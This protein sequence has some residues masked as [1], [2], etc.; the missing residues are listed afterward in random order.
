MRKS[1]GEIGYAGADVASA[2][3]T[4]GSAMP[5]AVQA[6]MEQ[7]LGA[8][9]SSVRVHEGPEAQAVGALAYAQGTNIH[10]APGQYD[11]GSQRGQELLGHELTHVMQ[12]AQGRVST[13]QSK[14]AP[15][16]QDP[17]LEHEADVRGAAAARGESIGGHAANGGAATRRRTSQAARASSGTSSP[18]QRFLSVGGRKLTQYSAKIGVVAYDTALEEGNMGA[19]RQFEEELILSVCDRVPYLREF[20]EHETH[21]VMVPRGLHRNEAKNVDYVPEQRLHQT[22][23]V[24]GLAGITGPNWHLTYEVNDG[25]IAL[26]DWEQTNRESITEEVIK[27]LLGLEDTRSSESED[28]NGMDVV[29]PNQPSVMIEGPRYIPRAYFYW[30]NYGLGSMVHGYIENALVIPTGQ[31]RGGYYE[32]LVQSGETPRQYQSFTMDRPFISPIQQ[33]VWFDGN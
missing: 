21:K 22:L 17:A 26:V 16:H 20:I 3:A 1:M 11:P 10:F 5:A 31:H 6:K 19:I 33:K 28:D 9:F 13:P 27:G 24:C 12:Q 8:D 18:I 29:E 25:A 14:G 2:P 15:I 4:G 30:S 23:Q 7:A 32:A